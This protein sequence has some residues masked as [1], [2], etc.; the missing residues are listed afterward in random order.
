MMRLLQALILT[1]VFVTGAYGR[2]PIRKVT[3]P[4]EVREEMALEV[5][6]PPEIEG[7]VWNRWTSENFTVLSLHDIQA[8]YLHKHLELVKVWVFSRWGLYNLPFTAECKMICVDDPD[9]FFKMFKIRKSRVEIRRDSQ[10]LIKETVI[11]L[12]INDAPSHTVPT[13]LTEICM[14]E[15]SQVYKQDTPWCL[16]KGMALLNGAL[17]QIRGELSEFAPA[18]EQNKPVYFLNGLFGIN[19]EKYA[20]LTP[21]N[22]RIFDQCSLALCLML[23]KEFGENKFHWFIKTASDNNAE[24]AVQEILKFQGAVDFDKTFRRYMIDITRDVTA[25][26]TPDDYLQITEMN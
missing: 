2:E 4:M 26:K 6:V 23:R 18:V 3:L 1:V 11:F 20:E 12:L 14:A 25:N 22:K 9:L 8:Q 19:K 13:P 10:G 15:F 16:V 7:K 5:T 24:Q 21:E 17:D